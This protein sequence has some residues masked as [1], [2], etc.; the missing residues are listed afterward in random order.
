MLT[1]REIEILKLRKKGLSQ[2]EI[3]KK[4]KISQP[5]I[6]D[7]VSNIKKKLFHSL[8]NLDVIKEIGIKYDKEK[9]ELKFSE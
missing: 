7:F 9:N 5:S 8:N 3:A 6:S 4:L 2:Q 1:N